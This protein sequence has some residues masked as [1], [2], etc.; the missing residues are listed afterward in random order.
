MPDILSKK[1]VVLTP[2]LLNSRNISFKKYTLTKKY[3]KNG[4]YKMS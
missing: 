3:N 1:T 4:D 2:L